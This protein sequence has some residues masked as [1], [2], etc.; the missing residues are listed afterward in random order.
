MF[1]LYR[2][3]DKTVTWKQVISISN[4]GAAKKEYG[5]LEEVFSQ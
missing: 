4:E 5:P 3:I 1:K 2:Q